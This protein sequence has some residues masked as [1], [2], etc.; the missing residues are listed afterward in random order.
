MIALTGL[1]AIAV[2]VAA[3]AALDIVR[4]AG[5]AL[6]SSRE[7]LARM[8]DVHADERERERAARRL[9]LRLFAACG[10]LIARSAIAIVAG[11][12]PIGVAH[13]SGVVPA[14]DVGRFLATWQAAAIASALAIVATAV[15]RMAWRTN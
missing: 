11:A 3:C 5:G 9:S 4:V 12:V 6:V 13:A 15:G 14:A 7:G 1:A 10:A 8:R 2:F